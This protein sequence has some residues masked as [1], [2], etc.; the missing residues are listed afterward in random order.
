MAAA[1][2]FYLL[3]SPGSATPGTEPAPVAQAPAASAAPAAM[4]AASAESA[5]QVAS[6]PEPPVAAISSAASTPAPAATSPPEAPAAAV[7]AVPA[8][9]TLRVELKNGWAKVLIDGEEK[10]VVP[11]LLVLSLE[12]GKHEVELINPSQPEV[13]QKVDVVAGK[14][15]VVRHAFGN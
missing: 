14:T 1:A 12:A 6:V 5:A 3:R 2:A 11:P 10:G 4:P 13:K 9:G 7:A 8:K 15:A